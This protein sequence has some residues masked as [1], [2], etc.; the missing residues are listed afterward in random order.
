MSS[1]LSETAEN[2]RPQMPK[3]ARL[4]IHRTISVMASERFCSTVWVVGAANFFRARP[5]TTAQ[6]RMPR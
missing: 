6:K 1:P 2:T 4:M 3:G 5:T